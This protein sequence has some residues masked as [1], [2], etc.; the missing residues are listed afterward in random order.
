MMHLVIVDLVIVDLR[1]DL[2]LKVGLSKAID[3]RRGAHGALVQGAARGLGAP[4][5][6]EPGSGAEP[7]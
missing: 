5:A 3:S 2:R 4:L 1:L 7:R 6:T